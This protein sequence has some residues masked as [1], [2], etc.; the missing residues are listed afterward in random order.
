MAAN[1]DPWPSA[2]PVDSGGS[3]DDALAAA[4]RHVAAA[5]SHPAHI[6]D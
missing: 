6:V 5:G 1:F 2:H 3:L 4:L